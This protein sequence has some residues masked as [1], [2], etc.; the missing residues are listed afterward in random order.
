[1]TKD[2][3]TTGREQDQFLEVIDRD[4]ADRRFRAV[5]DLTPL[6][7]ETVALEAA[8]G[9][10]LAA[11]VT[12]PLDVPFFDRSNVD[13]FAVRAADTFGASEEK[14]RRLRINAEVL[15]TGVEPRMEVAPGTA[16]V[17]ATGGMVPRGA[18]A[19]VMVE[20]TRSQNDEVLIFRPVVPGAAVSFA[21]SDIGQG[22]IVLR[23]GDL[24]SSRETGVLAALGIGRVRVFRR[25]RVAIIS[26]GD[27]IIAP[28]Q[29]MRSGLVYDSNAVIL[30]D[31]VRELVGA[32]RTAERGPVVRRGATVG[33][34]VQGRGRSVVS[35]GEQ[36]AAAARSGVGNRR[37][38][39]S[40]SGAWRGVET[41]Q[42]DLSGGHVHGA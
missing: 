31:A 2:G 24:L 28:G 16:T 7:E 25:P 36:V 22:E 15:A 26:T 30:A 35:C 32:G 10:V 41:G 8:L 5:L 34:H 42:A 19:V 29:P 21:G 9:R 40:H 14:P 17:I 4:E 27:E 1:M 6:G 13:G 12:A 39:I 37:S 20:F 23:R 38:A 3:T 33:R 11:D 18:D